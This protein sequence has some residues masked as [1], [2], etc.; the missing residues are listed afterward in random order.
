MSTFTLRLL[1]V[2]TLLLA[3]ISVGAAPPNLGGGLREVVA[4]YGRGNGRAAAVPMAH[5]GPS[6]FASTSAV[7]RDAQGRIN[8]SVHLD[9][10]RELTEVVAALRGVGADRVV[11]TTLV[12]HGAV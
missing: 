9:G 8:V 3:S 11:A 4:E 7:H 5:L 10:T 6:T 12:R 1:A 2:A